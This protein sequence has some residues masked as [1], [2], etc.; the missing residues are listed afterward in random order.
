MVCSN[1]NVGGACVLALAGRID[2]EG[3]AQL[4]AALFPPLTHCHDADGPLVLD[5]G[6]VESI[7]SAG[8]R[9]LYQAIDRV[10]KQHGR[11]AIAA[12]TPVVAETFEIT[13]FNRLVAC[14][15]NVAGAIASVAPASAS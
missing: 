5:F 15:D 3:S 9:V 11:I 1:R 4:Q 13:K 7:S 2:L 8:F 14:H 6:G 12:L 10:K